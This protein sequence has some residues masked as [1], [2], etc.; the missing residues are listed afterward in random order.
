MAKIVQFHYSNQKNEKLLKERG[1]GFEEIINSI[2]EGNLLA[3]RDHPNTLKYPKQKM[4][5]VR[6]VSEIYCVPFVLDTEES[7]YLKTLFASRK[8]RREFLGR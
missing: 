1:L 4:M 5:F 3:I 8:A 2:H 7:V 6:L